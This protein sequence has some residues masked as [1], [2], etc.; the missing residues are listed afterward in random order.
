M[1][2]RLSR[3]FVRNA[4]Q[5]ERWRSSG[6]D[7]VHK[8][9]LSSE[10]FAGTLDRFVGEVILP[11]DD[12][13]DKRRKLF[14]PLFQ[15][16]PSAILMC[17]TEI[18]AQIAVLF[19]A[20]SGTFMPGPGGSFPAAITVRSGGHS[21]AG[22]SAGSGTLIDV[23]ALNSITIAEDQSTVTVGCGCNF[24]KLIQILDAYGLHV[25][26]GECDDV[27]VGGF[28]QGGGYGF[29]SGA[30]G[31]NCD[32]A[33]SFRVLLSD[34]SIVVA[35]EST[36]RDLWWALRGGTGGNFG[37]VLSV[38]YKLYPLGQIY[39]WALAWPLATSDNRTDAVGAL[40]L[41]QANYMLTAPQY[42]TSQVSICYQPDDPHGSGGP[43]T[44]WLLI[45]GTY[46]APDPS[47]G[48]SVIAPL[49]DLPGAVT[50][51]SG[52]DSYG[53]L[54]DALLNF[55]YSIPPIPNAEGIPNED[56]Q[57]RYVARALTQ[58]EWRSILDLFVEQAPSAGN[59]WAYMYLEVYGGAI[60]AY[61]VADSAFIHRDV[62]F[63]ACLDVFWAIG[64][65]PSGAE[66]FLANWTQ[67]LET[68]WNGHIYQNYPN[69]NV[70][71]YRWN[72]WGS[73]LQ[74][75]IAVKAKYDGKNL[76]TFAQ[77]VAPYSP[78]EDRP[79]Q[80]TPPPPPI[81]E[82]LAKPIVIARPPPAAA[83]S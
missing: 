16:R 9:G 46:A 21:T 63:D 44:P 12:D 33:L 62:A 10:A 52:F 67:L 56:K 65:D 25:P 3:K 1:A 55:P 70:P 49:A 83:F 30:F 81:A 15:S 14:N 60:N 80:G 73:A 34:G 41:L 64:S 78:G 54:N 71:D 43:L 47:T 4:A 37:I 76:F 5:V 77:M 32:N 23:S 57:A 61:P 24:G 36:N 19:A 27:C 45:R 2:H 38:T 13:Y 31:M 51:Y 6:P 18:D 74:G 28:V 72:Y 69:Q 58:D 82:A 68:M 75:L 66:A 39:G 48:Q 11:G 29:T 79:E 50:Q 17:E 7:G 59:L 35:N 42:L 22:Y 26:T 40:M 20:Q 8:T 53:N